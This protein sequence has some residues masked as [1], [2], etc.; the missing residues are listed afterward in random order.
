MSSS[1]KSQACRIRPSKGLPV[2]GD[3]FISR[4][5]CRSSGCLLLSFLARAH[6]PAFA[7]IRY[8]VMALLIRLHIDS[9]ENPDRRLVA[10]YS[11]R[12]NIDGARC[13]LYCS[14]DFARSPSLGR[15]RFLLL[16]I[17][18][19]VLPSLSVCRDMYG[20]QVPQHLTE[21]YKTYSRIYQASGT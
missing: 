18:S 2:H 4:G 12:R 5:E 20:F 14:K 10:C 8:I 15:C 9:G 1:G 19:S 6:S 17:F 7:D 3:G 16:K 13:Q 21:K 11:Q